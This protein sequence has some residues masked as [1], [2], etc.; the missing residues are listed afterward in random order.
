MLMCDIFLYVSY[1]HDGE[2]M[3]NKIK[4]PDMSVGTF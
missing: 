3:G 1:P 2:S 4:G